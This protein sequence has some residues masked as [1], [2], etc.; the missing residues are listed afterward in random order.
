MAQVQAFLFLGSDLVAAFPFDEGV[1]GGT[2]KDQILCF[3][4]KSPPSPLEKKKKEVTTHSRSSIILE[5]VLLMITLN[6]G[7][8]CDVCAEEYGPHNCPHSIPCGHVLCLNCCNSI[9]EKTSPRLTPVCPF[10]R[11]QF[12][13]DTIRLIRIDFGNSGWSTPRRCTIEASDTGADIGDDDVL[14][15]NPGTFK[16]RAQV[17]RLESKVARV[18]AKK[19]SVEEVTTLHKEIEDWLTSDSK[20]DQSSSLALSA[21]LLRAILVNHVAHSEATRNFRHSEAQLRARATEAETEKEKLEM[22]VRHLITILAEGAGV[23]NTS[24][25]AQSYEDQDPCSESCRSCDPASTLVVFSSQQCARLSPAAAVGFSPSAPLR[26][27]VSNIP[28]AFTACSFH[29]L[30]PRSQPPCIYALACDLRVHHQPPVDDPFHSIWD[31]RRLRRGHSPPGH[32]TPK[33]RRLSTPSPPKMIRSGS[34]S[35]EKEKEK[36]RDARRVQL[37]QRWIPSVDAARSP[38]TGKSD[39]FESSIPVSSAAASARLASMPPRYKT[40]VSAHSP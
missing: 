26:C 17:R 2:K 1:F 40:P 6:P 9:I 22:E 25:G 34:S 35:D 7:S 23:S 30:A 4:A 39:K 36:L 15:L 14:L 3:T 8:L 13:S 16:S 29:V 33:P 5:R 27:Y 19:C 28:D 21:A 37:I 31:T 18:A 20:P 11:V 32:Y 38:P 12:S 10:C 24:C